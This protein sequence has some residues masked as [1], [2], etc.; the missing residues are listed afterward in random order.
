MIAW[1][2]VFVSSGAVSLL[3]FGMCAL[4]L[5]SL[6]RRQ[7]Q[8]FLVWFATS[9]VSLCGGALTLLAYGIYR[10]CLWIG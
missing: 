5:R 10:L 1:G 3:L 9:M 2:L 8:L 4:R 7:D 6:S